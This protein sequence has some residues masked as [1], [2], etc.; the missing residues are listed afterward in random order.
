MEKY[1]L[2]VPM[3]FYDIFIHPTKINTNVFEEL[4][5]IES[6]TKIRNGETQLIVSCV[7]EG[8]IG[9]WEIKYLENLVKSNNILL[10][11]FLLIHDQ[12]KLDTILKNQYNQT[13]LHRKANETKFLK[14]QGK[15]E[16]PLNKNRENKFHFPIRRFR[17]PRIELL[18]K[19]FVYDNNFIEQNLVSFD[20]TIL[21]NQEILEAFSEWMNKD[22]TDYLFEKKQRFIDTKFI[23][24]INKYGFEFHE[25]YQK[26][27]V[28][29]VSESFFRAKYN[30]ITE[31]TYKPIQHGHPFIIH[32]NSHI[33]DYIK[34]IGFKT[35]HPFIDESYDLEEDADKRFEMVLNEIKKLNEMSIEE[36]DKLIENVFEIL[37]HNQN[38]L[39]S[40]AKEDKFL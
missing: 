6:L 35:F 7:N 33:L 39:I 24:K 30:Y 36:L 21:E 10:D 19:L 38:H 26:S 27:Y 18:E 32:G 37:V 4:I 17:T 34:S 16:I 5:P 28:T 13:H 1:Y 2:T 9:E 23:E 25:T 29:I 14:K 22:F 8:D 20:T 11:N 15:F 3:N 31:K 40:F 12:F